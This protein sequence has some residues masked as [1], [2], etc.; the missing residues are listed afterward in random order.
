MSGW[1]GNGPSGHKVLLS[2]KD[3]RKRVASDTCINH[4][5]GLQEPTVRISNEIRRQA[6]PDNASTRVCLPRVLR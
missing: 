5:S 3:E 2:L 6:P 1:Q 4:Y